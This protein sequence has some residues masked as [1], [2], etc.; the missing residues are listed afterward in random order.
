[1]KRSEMVKLMVEEL[2]RWQD[3]DAK[4]GGGF[5]SCMDSILK[6]QEEA[7][8]LP[9]SKIESTLIGSFECQIENFRICEKSTYDEIPFKWE[10]E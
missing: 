10:D 7:G 2:V 5:E 9:P 8:M 1:M 3:E 6:A 4:F